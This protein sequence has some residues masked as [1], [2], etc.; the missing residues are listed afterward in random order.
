MREKTFWEDGVKVIPDDL[1]AIHDLTE[2]ESKNLIEVL[3]GGLSTILFDDSPPVVTHVAPNIVV[4]VPAQRFAVDGCT[5]EISAPATLNFA[6]APAAQHRVFF[7][8]RRNDS[9]DTRD[10]LQESGGTLSVV[11]NL[12]VVRKTTTPRIEQTS[13]P[14][15]LTPAPD[16]A[17]SP[18][19]IG[20]VELCTIIWDGISTLTLLPNTGALYTFPGAG[21]AYAPHAIQHLPGGGDPLQIAAIDASPEGSRVG[22]MPAG[23]YAVLRNAL[24]WVEIDG[25][26]PYLVRVNSGDNSPTNPKKVT[27]GLNVTASFVSRD[28][29][30]TW[31]LALNFP[32]G[33]YAGTSVSPARSDH[34]H[35]PSEMPLTIVPYSMTVDVSHLGQIITVPDFTTIGN[36][37]HIAVYWV[38]L[39]RDF[40]MIE[41][42]WT[43][44]SAGVVGTRVHLH[45]SKAIR[46]ETGSLGFTKM[47]EAL[48]NYVV[49][50]TGGITWDS[51]DNG[52]ITRSGKLYVRLFG[53]R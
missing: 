49:G 48:K 28:E 44:T 43:E 1:N 7:V 42:G 24:Q 47:T 19:D 2:D 52:K 5:E 26:S 18:D 32:N 17:L 22:L 34:R 45:G 14:N 8:I 20:F 3:S 35:L 41:C 12:V 11:S 16:P 40:P 27:I 53:E 51:Q 39:G 15:I 29:S 36:I 37:S 13:S 4:D 46:I 50:I 21:M 30:G 25:A 6:D 10:V 31:Y 9:T 33:P 38:P 23:S